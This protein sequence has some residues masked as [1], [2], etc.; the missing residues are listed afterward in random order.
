M[1]EWKQK[2]N[3]ELSRMG[4]TKDMCLRNV[5]IGF[6]PE[7]PPKYYDAKAAMIANRS[8]GTL[9]SMNELPKNISVPVFV[10]TSSPNEHVEISINGTLYSD[11]KK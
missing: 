11:G 2:R 1:G 3:F 9:H 7:I 6:N 10:D 4:T 8:A 5:R